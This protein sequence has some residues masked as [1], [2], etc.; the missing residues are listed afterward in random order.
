MFVPA[1]DI[2]DESLVTEIVAQDY[3][4]SAVFRK[5]GIEF[6]CG[7]RIP[8]QTACE[9]HGVNKDT[10]KKELN[11][12][13]RNLHITNAIDFGN[14]DIDFLIDYIRNIHHEYLVKN[15]PEAG[16]LLQRFT[17]SH[18]KKYPWLPGLMNA[19]TDLKKIMLPHLQHEEDVI[20][21][22]IRQIAHAHHNREPYA[23]LL[24]R[25]LRKPVEEMM[26]RE[27]EYIRNYLRTSRELTNNYTPP[28]NACITHR[29]C[30]SKL[31][32]LDN[33]LVQ[34]THLENNILFPKA[35]AM[36]KEL[37]GSV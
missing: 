11:N 21:P 29:V 4:T 17:D 8:L 14:W 37:L 7:G 1:I 30:F 25:T 3:R 6:C 34:H 32:E 10:I 22:Y 18:K 31:Q 19:F 26:E 12:S 24:V 27:H 5:Y 15:L 23:A 2:T 35:I 13:I 20:F 36:E 33:D 16:D 28:E 9:I